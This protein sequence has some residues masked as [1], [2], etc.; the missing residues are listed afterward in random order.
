MIQIMERKLRAACSAPGVK[1]SNVIQ[2]CTDIYAPLKDSNGD[3]E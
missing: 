2:V 3:G 1:V